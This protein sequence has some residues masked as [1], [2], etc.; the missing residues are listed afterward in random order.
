MNGSKPHHPSGRNERPRHVRSLQAFPISFPLTP[1][2]SL[3][4]REARFP[5]LQHTCDGIRPPG[6][7]RIHDAQYVLP[8]PEPRFVAA[9]RQSA[10]IVSIVSFR[11]SAESPL[12]GSCSQ[13]APDSLGLDVLK[14]L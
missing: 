1:T 8:P 6:A 9:S 7:E 13:R 11:R 2:L 3:G 10:G 4:E 5:I 12:R 14:R